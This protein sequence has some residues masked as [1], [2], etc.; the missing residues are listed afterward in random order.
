MLCILWSYSLDDSVHCLSSTN[1]PMPK[2]LIKRAVWREID[3]PFSRPQWYENRNTVGFEIG[4]IS[5]ASLYWPCHGTA[6]DTHRSQESYKREIKHSIWIDNTLGS[7]KKEYLWYPWSIFTNSCKQQFLSRVSLPFKPLLP[8]SYCVIVSI[9]YGYF[10][11]F[12]RKKNNVC[13]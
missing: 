4:I 12:K 5:T 6:K 11:M 8:S 3:L 2:T 7:V 9:L 10:S 13:I 1:N